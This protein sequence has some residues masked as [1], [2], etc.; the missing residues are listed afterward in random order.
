[1]LNLSQHFR[2]NNFYNWSNAIIDTTTVN[3]KP[4]PFESP[5]CGAGYTVHCKPLLHKYICVLP[6]IYIVFWKTIKNVLKFIKT[7][8]RP[9][10]IRVVWFI[11]FIGW[12]SVRE[13][14]TTPLSSSMIHLSAWN[15]LA[16]PARLK[17]NWNT[18]RLKIRPPYATNEFLTEFSH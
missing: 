11:R 16:K 8:I 2:C 6:S 17:I 10:S 18:F 9:L 4:V 14:F 1:M 5:P 15:T 3:S 7:L 12:H 13:A